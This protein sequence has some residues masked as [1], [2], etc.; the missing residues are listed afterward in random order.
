MLSEPAVELGALAIGKWEERLGLRRVLNALPKR[1]GKLDPLPDRELQEV[2]NID[3]GH[4]TS[5]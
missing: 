2:I 1:H 3:L 5:L 4:G